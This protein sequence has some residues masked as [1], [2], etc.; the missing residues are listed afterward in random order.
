MKFPK[1]MRI[2]GREIAYRTQKPVGIFVLNWRRIRDGV[3]SAEDTEVYEKTHK[4]FLDNLPEPPFYGNDNEN[5]QG[6]VTW[7]KTENSS[8]MLEHIQP[9][10]DLLEK[11]DIPYDIVYSNYV[12]KVIYEDD[13]QV[14]VIDE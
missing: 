3:Y 13:Y 4:W 5:P 11:Y 6:A 9:L 14:G 12:G 1:Y 8:E 2:Q 10:I 7:F